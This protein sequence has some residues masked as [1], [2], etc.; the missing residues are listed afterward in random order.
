M[1]KYKALVSSG[2]NKEKEVNKAEYRIA[3]RE[4]KKVVA[5]AKN[6]AFKRLYH[7]LGFKEGEKEVFKLAR[8]R[9]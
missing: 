3:K 9:E 8:A 2:T 6:N 1:E 7:R 5:V 4:A